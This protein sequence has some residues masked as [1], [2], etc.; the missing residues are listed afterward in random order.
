MSTLSSSPGDSA[1][2]SASVLGC[3]KLG[4]LVSEFVAG[5][6]DDFSS[7][8]LTLAPTSAREAMRMAAF[9][10]FTMLRD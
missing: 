2:S 3:W 8:A 9:V 4:V 10:A 6:P 7:A 5:L 1:K